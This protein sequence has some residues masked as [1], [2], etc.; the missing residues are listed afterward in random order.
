VGRVTVTQVRGPQ[1]QIEGLLP[2]LA[3]WI[4]RQ[5][6]FGGKDAKVSRV[7]L[8]GQT[9]LS[10]ANPE[11]HHVVVAVDQ[12][13]RS[14][15]YQLFVSVYAA[16]APALEPARISNVDGRH[17]Y[18]AL[19]DPEAAGLLL[20]HMVNADQVGDLTFVPEP[21]VSLPLGR[22]ATVLAAEQSNTSVVYGDVALFK[23]FRR[24]Q[25]G[26]N[27][28]IEV[29]RA[30]TRDGCPG[31]AR[32]L[33]SLEGAWADPETG[34][35]V[36]GSLGMLQ[37]FLDMAID[38]WVRATTS[39]R[40]SVSE[41]GGDFTEESERLGAAT[42]EVH[43]TMARVLPHGTWDTSDL[44]GLASAM[45]ARL[46]GAI[47]RV[48]RLAAYAAG[49][50]AAYDTLADVPVPLP[51]QRV[52]G[53]LHL[54]QALYSPTGWVI[55]DFEGEP[56]K[57]LSE[58]VA[59]Q[60]TARDVAGMLRSFDYA[61]RHLVIGATPDARAAARADAWANDNRAAYCE[62]YARLAG[63]DPRADG[64]ILR[65]FEADKAVYE[66]VYEA[67]NRPHW[68]PIPIATLER[69]ARP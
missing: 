65:A 15:A 62:G 17:A 32:L 34:A 53:D 49:L 33:G 2:V 38:G 31:I 20:Q 19:H 40:A 29:H 52:H 10:A 60:P 18:D 30:L 28:D 3:S 4:P 56:A 41:T 5:R 22:T 23:V 45:H 8:L 42:A 64:A 14:E 59:L 21:D 66:A 67:N 35:V 37:A 7:R 24:L 44:R 68:L 39:V 46:D 25:V 9:L 54:G 55:V 1:F 51:V 50:R 11:V 26:T 36:S 13:D 61:A 58:R 12:P 48:P 27:P 63:R 16:P 47:T 69:L 57:P 6:W 43:K